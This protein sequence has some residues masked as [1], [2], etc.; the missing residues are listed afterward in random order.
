MSGLIARFCLEKEEEGVG[1]RGEKLDRVT[2]F[3]R[4]H[5]GKERKAYVCFVSGWVTCT[6]QNY[7][8]YGRGDKRE[9]RETTISDGRNIDPTWNQKSQPAL[10]K[11]DS[12]N[13]GEASSS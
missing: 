3:A 1:T 9:K 12:P 7:M 10:S 5:G 2:E 6:V 8:I 13:L 11:W 4:L